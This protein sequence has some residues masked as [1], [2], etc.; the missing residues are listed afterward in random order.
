MNN[1]EL[2]VK[3]YLVSVHEFLPMVLEEL[4]SQITA[5][6]A[7]RHRYYDENCILSTHLVLKHKELVVI[8]R[9]TT[10]PEIHPKETSSLLHLH[11]SRLVIHQTQWRGIK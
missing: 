4:P 2:N 5:V 9:I 3:C 7:D 10:T 6:S 11:Y 1:T 8:T